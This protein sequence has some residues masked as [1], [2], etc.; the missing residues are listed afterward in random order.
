MPCLDMF[1]G[2]WR[3]ER[4]IEDAKSGQTTRF[5]G[6]A[7]FTPDG[8]GL[9]YDEEGQMHLPGQPPMHA[10]RRYLWRKVKG[11]ID[12]LFDDGRPF[13]HIGGGTEPQADHICTPDLYQVSYD[14]GHW[15]DWRATW[16]VSGPR[17]DYVMHSHYR[18]VAQVQHGTLASEQGLGHSSQSNSKRQNSHNAGGAKNGLY[19][20]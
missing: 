9:I 6:T 17:K 11:G 5:D 20:D 10:S 7:L 4:D 15:P 16:R 8:K 2:A 1:A 13:H 3:V 14:F 12:V 18:P 19:P